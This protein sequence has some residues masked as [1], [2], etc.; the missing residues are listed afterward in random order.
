MYALWMQADGTREHVLVALRLPF[1]F[2]DQFLAICSLPSGTLLTTPL[3]TLQSWRGNRVT[4]AGVGVGVGAG[5]VAKCTGQVMRQVSQGGA[6]SGSPHYSPL[7]W[8]AG[9]VNGKL[10][11]LGGPLS[12]MSDFPAPGQGPTFSSC[13]VSHQLRSWFCLP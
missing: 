1:P 3:L 5:R 7:L 2:Q 10:E 13:T 6:S 11:T 8:R 4:W 9:W 12:A